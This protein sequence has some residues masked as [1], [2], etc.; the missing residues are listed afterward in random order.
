LRWRSGKKPFYYRYDGARFWFASEVRAI[1]SDPDVPIAVDS[2][3][4]QSYL[5]LGFVP[6][7][8]SAFQG[9]ARL[10]PGHLALVDRQ[11]F[12]QERYWQLSYTPKRKLNS[13]EATAE[14][15]A[16]LREAV[17]L[18]LV[19][20]VPLGAFLSGGVDSAAVVAAMC[21][22]SARVE[23]FSIGFDHKQY[24]ELKYAREVAARLGTT[25][26]EF[27][28]T[29]DASAVAPKLAWHYGEPYADSSAVPTY[30]LAQ[31]ARSRITVALNGDGG[32]ESFAGYTRYQA[33]HMALRYQRLP[34]ALRATLENVAG[35]L[36][37]ASAKSKAHRVGR[38]FRG[39][40][41]PSYRLY[42]RWFEFF[43][44]HDAALDR[45]SSS[46]EEAALAPLRQ[47]FE[48]A[49]GLQPVEAAMA[50]DVALYLPDDL[51]VKVDIATMAHGLEARSP[52][53]DHQLMEFAARLPL[54]L[55]VRHGQK[56]WLLKRVLRG[57]VPEGVLRRPKMGFG[58]PL[59]SWFRSSLRPMLN[60][61]LGAEQAGRGFF[62]PG[63][64]RRLIDEHQHERTAHGQRLWCVLMLELWFR[65]YIDAARPSAT[66]ESSI[67][68]PGHA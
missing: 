31:L 10:L 63:A 53:L 57:R 59:D 11:G 67:A 21:E 40:S 28:V 22:E 33:Y 9:I 44:G 36:T 16:R 3:A 1:L 2:A 23:T 49:A 60:D 26:H 68:L 7:P 14:L 29:P 4:I 20:D 25:H 56:K 15:H 24:D 38:F 12:R 41:F 35:R 50:A 5:R 17:R 13:R 32:D 45:R 42:A 37:A 66:H 65:T 43:G 52:L 58:V 27:V 54:N 64:V 62:R 18:R 34:P 30:Y 8:Q 19:S 61:L 6:A 39:A 47:A 55:K 46:D 51:L 48:H